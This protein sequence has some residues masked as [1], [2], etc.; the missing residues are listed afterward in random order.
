MELFALK[1]NSQR[2]KIARMGNSQNFPREIELFLLTTCNHMT[3]NCKLDKSN[4]NRCGEFIL[5]ANSK[6]GVSHSNDFQNSIWPWTYW[7]SWVCSATWSLEFV[8]YDLCCPHKQPRTQRLGGILCYS[9]PQR[10]WPPPE[11]AL[12]SPMTDHHY[13]PALQIKESGW[14]HYI[15]K[16]R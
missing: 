14:Q 4:T 15:L 1:L 6:F 7:Q 9:A 10:T 3:E 13:W 11:L 5:I 12:G 16:A 8:T 2:C